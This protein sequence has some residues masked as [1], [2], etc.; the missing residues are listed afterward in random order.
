MQLQQTA[1]L[2]LKVMDHGESDKI[3]TCLCPDKGKLTGI[4][5]G[6]KRSKKRFVNKLEPYTLLNL[7]FTLGRHSSLVRIDQAELLN[8][9]PALR[10]DYELYTAAA[11]ICELL[12]QWTREN[13]GDPPLFELSAWALANLD[14]GGPWAET[15]ILFQIKLFTLLGYRPQLSGCGECGT[16]TASRAPYRFS[17]SRGSLACAACNREAGVA[18]LPLALDT[19]SLLRLAQ[20]LPIIKL[21]RLR[22]SPP[23]AREALVMLKSYGCHL[24]QRDLHSWKHLAAV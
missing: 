20:D 17:L 1:A 7:E 22:F 8:P 19:A 24:L 15:L 5:K 4:A 9:F 6:A 14:A 2:V 11:L 12:L 13:D 16:L 23:S 21:S 10:R 18:T 3:V